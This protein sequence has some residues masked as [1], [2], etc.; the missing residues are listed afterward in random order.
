MTACESFETGRCYSTAVDNPSHSHYA[1]VVFTGE[2]SIHS[3]HA[4]NMQISAGWL[5]REYAK[6]M[7][8]STTGS[9]FCS[10]EENSFDGEFVVPEFAAK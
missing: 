9:V 7:S 6:A 3:L 10:S 5:S 1:V 8:I 2:E 4:R